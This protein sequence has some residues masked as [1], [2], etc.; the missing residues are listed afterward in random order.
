MKIVNLNTVTVRKLL[1]QLVPAPATLR[2]VH[3]LRVG[4]TWGRGTTSVIITSPL[5]WESTLREE[6]ITSVNT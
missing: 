4:M 5:L 3:Q 6:C 1:I 2:L